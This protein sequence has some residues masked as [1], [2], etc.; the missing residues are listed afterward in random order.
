MWSDRKLSFMSD[1]FRLSGI[2][3]LP[4]VHLP[5]V[6]IGSH[7]LLSTGNSPKQIELA[8]QCV[9][10]GMA[11]FRFDHRGCGESDGGKADA[12][13]FQGRCRDLRCA[14]SF[15]RNN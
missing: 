6:V 10:A 9:A 14:I 7:G 1:G 15:L 2:L 12:V 11:Y 13:D 5:P 4:E 8:G 3:H